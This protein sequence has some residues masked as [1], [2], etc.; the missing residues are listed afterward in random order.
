MPSWVDSD[1]RVGATSIAVAPKLVPYKLFDGE[2]LYLEV[3]PTGARRW[4]FKYRIHGKEKRISL[5]VYPEV[6]LKDAR[7]KLD[8]VRKQGS[9]FALR[10]PLLL[11]ASIRRLNP[12]VL[13]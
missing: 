1:P 3:V 7:E 10:F 13:R 12:L 11:P 9:K 8:E 4:R 6:G 5:G 2:G